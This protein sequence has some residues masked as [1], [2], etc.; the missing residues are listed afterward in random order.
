[1][2]EGQWNRGNMFGIGRYQI[3]RDLPH[4]AEIGS[5]FSNDFNQGVGTRVLSSISLAAYKFGERWIPVPLPPPAP[6]ER[7]SPLRGSG[8]KYGERLFTIAGALDH[9]LEGRSAVRVVSIT[10]PVGDESE[11]VHAP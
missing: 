9:L 2:C 11:P 7:C 10:Q 4:L 6:A 5:Q 3:G 1:M 8:A